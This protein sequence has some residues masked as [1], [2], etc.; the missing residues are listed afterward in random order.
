MS[1]EP[2][3]AASGGV[4]SAHVGDEPGPVEP[5]ADT[6]AVE[7]DSAAPDD[8]LY[9]AWVLI[10]NAHDWHLGYEPQHA[11]WRE[12]AIRWRDRW[13]A[14]LDELR[15]VPSSSTREDGE[16]GGV[17]GQLAAL[18][19]WIDAAPA[20]A[21]R[22]R[23]AATWGRLAKVSEE[24]GEVREAWLDY[25]D[26]ANGR[27]IAAFIGAT[28]QNPRKG[29]THD[30]TDVI[31]E[32]LDVALT[33]LCAVEHMTGNGGT[34]MGQF[35]EHVRSVAARA[36]L[37]PNHYADARSEYRVMGFVNGLDYAANLA[38]GAAQ[39]GGEQ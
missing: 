34:S 32:L 35:S 9:D 15:P 38:R 8:L 14:T 10:A 22:D 28:E 23:E 2:N 5:V 29:H 1:T 7:R 18:S 17:A 39:P 37:E 30:R 36:G 31:K 27:L 26:I 20:N 24:I 4:P 12:A 21:A 13:H 16:T 25:L 11:E 19:E 33:A 3:D 6:E